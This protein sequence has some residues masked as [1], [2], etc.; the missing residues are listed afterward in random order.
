MK[1]ETK[2]ETSKRARR[3][4]IIG[5]ISAGLGLLLYVLT[6]GR[7][8]LPAPGPGGD[9]GQPRTNTVEKP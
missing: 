8:P 1:M 5:L 9:S 3:A 7:W 6:G 4:K 2:V